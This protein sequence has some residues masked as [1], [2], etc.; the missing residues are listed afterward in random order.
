MT[1][2]IQGKFTY[3]ASDFH[4]GVPD[5]EKSLQRER[6]L[7]KWLDEIKDKADA[8]YFL[9]DIFDFWFEYKYV[10]PKG[11]VR[12]LG[13]LAELSDAGIKLVI[14]IGNHDMWIK[15][16]L[17]KEI[18]ATI[19]RGPIQTSIGNHKFYLAHGD[20]IG[21]G[22]YGYKFIK[23]IFKNPICQWLFSRLHPN[24]AFG[25]ANFFSKLSRN[26]H[27]ETD[28]KFLGNDKEWLVTYSNEIQR[29]QH[30]DF[31]VYGHRHL[32]LEIPLSAGATY[33]NLGDWLSYNSYGVYDGNCFRLNY[34]KG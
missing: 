23:Q 13:K 29:K 27:Q 7:V 10:V 3:F 24:F 20:G 14:F 6:L 32:P 8:I 2:P 28:K 18:G 17:E 9:G 15:D 30:F 26:A 11:Y 19:I 21:P 22:D 4:L 1:T 31:Y 5:F 34:Y 12:L 16:Y 33:I 25:L